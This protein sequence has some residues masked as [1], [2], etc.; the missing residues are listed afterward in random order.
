MSPGQGPTITS[1]TYYS[2]CFRKLYALLPDWHMGAEIQPR[3][4]QANT[5]NRPSCASYCDSYSSDVADVWAEL[6]TLLHPRA[7][8]PCD[9]RK[10]FTVIGCGDACVSTL[11]GETGNKWC[12]EASLQ[13]ISLSGDG[14]MSQMTLVVVGCGDGRDILASQFG[15]LWVLRGIPLMFSGRSWA[16]S[17]LETLWTVN[18]VKSMLFHVFD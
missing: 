4:A 9:C 13:M 1:H 5:T 3:G 16:Q 6:S 14:D 12:F 17:W 10:Y 7:N 8:A 11:S 18:S 2:T 15:R